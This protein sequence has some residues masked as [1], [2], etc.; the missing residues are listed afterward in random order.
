MKSLKY[1]LAL[2]LILFVC[3]GLF[4]SYSSECNCKLIC[5]NCG[6]INTNHIHPDGG[7]AAQVRCRDCDTEWIEEN[8]EEWPDPEPDTTGLMIIDL[9]H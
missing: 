6:G 3:G 2:V 9:T 1:I 4:A 8:P 5:P 7:I